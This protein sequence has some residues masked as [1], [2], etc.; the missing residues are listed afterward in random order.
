MY[1]A[2]IFT[3]LVF[4]W[5]VRRWA[6]ARRDPGAGAADRNDVGLH[7]ALVARRK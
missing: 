6:N 4:A 1:A 5:L 3:A 7:G 2:I